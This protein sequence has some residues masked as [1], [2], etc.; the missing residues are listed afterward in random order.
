MFYRVTRAS[1][2]SLL[3][4]K[5]VLKRVY[6]S[7]ALYLNVGGTHLKIGVIYILI[8]ALNSKYI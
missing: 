4:T 2:L 6:L 1:R 5:C 3:Q 8:V 7:H